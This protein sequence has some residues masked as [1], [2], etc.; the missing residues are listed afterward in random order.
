M[1]E[2]ISKKFLFARKTTWRKELQNFQQKNSRKIRVFGVA[3]EK[4]MFL[5]VAL[6]PF[7]ILGVKFV[8]LRNFSPEICNSLQPHRL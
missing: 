6:R 8:I 1:A 7:R 2:D 3:R 4:M 5:G